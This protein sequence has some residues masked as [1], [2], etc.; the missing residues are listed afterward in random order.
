MAFLNDWLLR[1]IMLTDKRRRLHPG[2]ALQGA[3]LS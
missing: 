2:A 1:H 3:G